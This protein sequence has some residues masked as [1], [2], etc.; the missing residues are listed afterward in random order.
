MI[1]IRSDEKLIPIMKKKNNEW[2]S[3]I[4]FEILLIKIFLFNLIESTIKYMIN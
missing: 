3:L 2:T 4:L 1:S